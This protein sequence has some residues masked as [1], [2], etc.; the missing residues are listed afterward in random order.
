LYLRLLS[1]HRGLLCLPLLGHRCQRLRADC[2]RRLLRENLN[3][4]VI[5]AILGIAELIG[6]IEHGREAIHYLT[7]NSLFVYLWSV[8][9]LKERILTA[10][11]LNQCRRLALK[12][13]TYGRFSPL[14]N[15]PLF[16]RE[17]G[18]RVI[19]TRRAITQ[20]SSALSKLFA[21]V[22]AKIVKS[23]S[24]CP[25]CSGLCVPC[26]GRRGRLHLRH[27]A[28]KSVEIHLVVCAHRVY[29]VL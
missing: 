6:S 20:P 19:L 13:R 11:L 28:G 27:T 16:G 2:R 21:L 14:K 18:V 3:K 26:L 22:L 7:A 8:K 15:L 23:F 24:L 4:R 17:Q 10:E 12:T 25:E 5:E 1:A 29:L 9:R